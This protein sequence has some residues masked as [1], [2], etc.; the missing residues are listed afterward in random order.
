MI[1][2]VRNLLWLGV[3][4]AAGCASG[5]LAALAAPAAAAGEEGR[6]V[7]GERRVLRSAILGENRPVMIYRPPG[8]K[9]G[10]AHPVVYVLDGEAHFIHA[11]G[12]MQFLAVQ[13]RMPPVVVVG[14]GNVHRTRDLTPTAVD[15]VP[16]SGGA[17][18]FLGFIER[19]LIPTVEE[20]LAPHPY[21]VLVGHS[22]GGLLA[23]RALNRSPDLFDAT[24]AISPSLFWGDEL[25][26]KQSQKLFAV[27]PALDRA[28]YLA[29]GGESP[30]IMT[31]T[32]AYAELLRSEGPRGPR[33]SF[34]EMPEED[35]GSIV[36]RGI[37]RGLEHVFAGWRPS[38]EVDTMAE[39][40]GAYRA[41]AVRFRLPLKVPEAQ[42]NLFAYRL[43]AGGR[44]EEAVAAFRRNIELYPDSANVYD[45]LG[46]ALEK[47][48]DVDEAIRNYDQAARTA[49]TNRD[50]LLEV[51]MR[52]LERARAGL[53]K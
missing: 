46:E 32:R 49:A 14:V 23:I 13:R 2:R 45:S 22:Y 4:C 16:T 21:R 53:K 30:E 19:E 9:P 40:E 48:G 6:V 25:M 43:L 20:G 28:L 31:S 29:I 27:R 50:P 44:N 10:E 11:A 37:Y 12:L 18:R 15:S 42:L 1:R 51:F 5:A 38:A 39:L 36:H 8:M 3:L 26:R 35:H 17:D 24:I 41:L 47:Q 52:N 33:W 34:E 7:L